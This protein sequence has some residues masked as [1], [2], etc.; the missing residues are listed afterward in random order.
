MKVNLLFCF[1]HDFA[2]Y[3][4]SFFFF[5]LHSFPTAAAGGEGPPS[6]VKE[7]VL[8]FAQRHNPRFAWPKRPNCYDIADSYI[9][10]LYGV[11][12]AQTHAAMLGDAQWHQRP[13]PPFKRDAASVLFP[14]PPCPALSKKDDNTVSSKAVAPRE[15]AAKKRAETAEA[16]KA[17]QAKWEAFGMETARKMRAQLAAKFA[18]TDEK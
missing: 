8:S 15:T 14:F 3:F 1:V 5:F 13:S 16:S 10:A 6:E 17:H 18:S 9:I 2:S 4:S 7:R 11:W 12:A